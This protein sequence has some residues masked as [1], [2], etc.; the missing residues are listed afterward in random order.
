MPTCMVQVADQLAKFQLQV[1][2]KVQDPCGESLLSSSSESS[3]SSSHA[4]SSVPPAEENQRQPML[5]RG[6]SCRAPGP[7]SGTSTGN[8]RP[9]SLVED[10]RMSLS[11]FRKKI[12]KPSSCNV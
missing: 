5:R 10:L 11:S 2:N 12:Y 7:Q 9:I 8:T 1:P 4:P 3:G 6:A